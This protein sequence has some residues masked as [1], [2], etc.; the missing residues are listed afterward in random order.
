MVAVVV[1][2]VLGGMVCWRLLRSRGNRFCVF[3]L[4]AVTMEKERDLGMVNET[5][6]EEGEGELLRL[7]T[8]L[9]PGV[10]SREW[11]KL[12]ERVRHGSGSSVGMPVADVVVVHVE[13]DIRR[14]RL[15]GRL[16]L[17][18]FGNDDGLSP[19]YGESSLSEPK[20][21]VSVSDT[22]GLTFGLCMAT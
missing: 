5:V 1:A 21:E 8:G 12:E 17:S 6:G 19:V 11:R 7:P 22:R 2:L 13:V 10:L 14:I 4:V 16:R 9:D 15:G 18:L 3:V 20:L